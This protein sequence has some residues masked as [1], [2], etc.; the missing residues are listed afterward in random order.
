MQMQVEFKGGAYW[1]ET[2]LPWGTKGGNYSKEIRYTLYVHVHV[3]VYVS[4]CEGLVMAVCVCVCVCVCVQVAISEDLR[5]TLNA[6]LYRTGES[7]R[8]F[9]CLE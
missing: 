4:L 8:R 2:S 3:H 7:S 9:A 1:V 6:F 5:G